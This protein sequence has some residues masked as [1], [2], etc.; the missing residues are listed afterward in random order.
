MTVRTKT[1]KIKTA[2]FG[3]PDTKRN[4]CLKEEHV[5]TGPVLLPSEIKALPK[6]RI[7]SMDIQRA[8][9]FA[10]TNAGPRE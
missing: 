3:R 4:E 9:I 5:V 6:N 7:E 1:M 8:A 10:Q 2:I